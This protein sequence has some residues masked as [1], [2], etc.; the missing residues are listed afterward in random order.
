MER[1]QE[2]GEVVDGKEKMMNRDTVMGNSGEKNK[3]KKGNKKGLAWKIIYQNIRGLVTNRSR[4]KIGILYEEGRFDKILLMN[5]T[6]TWL[7][8]ET[9]ICPEMGGYRLYRGDRSHRGGGGVAIYVKS[10]FEAQKIAE[11][12]TDEVEMVAVYIEKLNIINIV[13]YRPPGTKGKNFSE[14]LGKVKEILRKVKTPEPTVVITGDFNFAFV[15]W[16]RGKLGGCEWKRKINTGATRDEQ[17]QFER[18]N[19]QMD[20]FGLIQIID[21]P[22][23]EEN[24]L[25]LIYTNESSMVMNV[26]CTKSNLSD[27]NRIEIT[28]NIKT[29]KEDELENKKR[30]NEM[31]MRGLNYTD[32]NIEWDKI[33][34]EL[35]EIQWKE[36]FDGKDTKTCLNIFLKIIVE[37]CSKYIPEKKTKS[38]N[39]IPKRRKQLFQKIK[40]LRRSKNRAN[41]KRKKEIDKKILEAEKEIINHK[42]EER[43]RKEKMVIE[44]MNKKTKIF[45]DFI[46]N[47]ENRENKLGPFKVEG[48]YIRSN[49]EMCNTM[50][51]QYNA[52]YSN[53]NNK[54]KMN[55]K[56]FDNIQENDITDIAIG[57]DDIRTAIGDIDPNSTAGPEGVSAKFLRETKDSIAVPLAK[58][59]RNSID[60]CEIPDILKLAY[61]TPIHKGGSRLNP[62]NYRPVSLTSHI[63]K[64]FER[65]I[66]IKLTEHL[67]KEGLIN[68]GQHGFVE[69]RSTQTQLLD[70]FCRVYEALEEGVRMDTVYLDFAKAFDKVDHEILMEKLAENKIK[71]KLD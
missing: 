33:R 62:E 20:E 46:K 57:E 13:I 11:M 65:V 56:L 53:N 37:L 63:M 2:T 45:H 26:E 43:R 8:S 3:D 49:K 38:K 36:I 67:R 54:H 14:V 32:E 55:D 61:V 9:E 17:R 21:E 40:L 7:N 30:E 15:E 64:V 47:K 34:T 71:G 29:R 5:F 25:D 42:R 28:T 12:S 19:E 69:G 68:K 70:H 52:Q 59:L 44:N 51:K 27:H 1:E 31:G 66:K 4:E 22:T 10:E 60:K 18:L 41:N 39:I 50:T 16:T 48:Q 24:T 35:E 58:I 23:R 6:E